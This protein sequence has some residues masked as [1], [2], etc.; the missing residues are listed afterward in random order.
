MNQRIFPRTTSAESNVAPSGIST[1]ARSIASDL[2]FSPGFGG[3]VVVEAVPGALESFV[4]EGSDW[5]AA[6][7]AS[8]SFVGDASAGDGFDGEAGDRA[9]GEV[10]ALEKMVSHRVVELCKIDLLD[11][12][13][14]RDVRVSFG[15]SFLRLLGRHDV[16]V[17]I[18][19]AIGSSSQNVCS[20]TRMRPEG[21]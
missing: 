12:F 9:C 21:G 11:A 14:R 16:L 7:G 18:R 17:M 1:T 3:V 6:P 19:S 13:A 5:E 15:E 8:E 2:R 20:R 10:L 4:G